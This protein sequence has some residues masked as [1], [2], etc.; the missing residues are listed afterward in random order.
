MFGRCLACFVLLVASIPA[1]A[2]PQRLELEWILSEEGKTATAVPQHAWLEDGRILLYDRRPPKSE[3]TL[4]I[5]DP[6][7][8]RTRKAIDANKVVA[9]MNRVLDPDEPLDEPGWPTDFSTDG[10]W[11]AYE[12]SGDIILL[13]LR[14][15]VVTAVAVSEAEE[16]SPK[17]SPDGQWLAFVR[18]NDLYARN[19]ET[20]SETRLTTGGTGTLMNGRL[21]WVYWEEF[22][23]RADR[24]FVW[25]PDS[26]SIA[27][28]QSDDS[29]VG[30]MHF[31]DFKP[32]LPRLVTQRHP[33]AGEPNP[34]VRAGV[35]NLQDAKTTWIDMG[36]YPY[37]YLPRLQWLPDSR[38]LA[39]Q[40]LNRSQSVLD[41]FLADAGTGQATHLMRET[42]DGWVNVHDDLYFLRDGKH[43]LWLSERSGYAHLYLYDLDGELV[44]Q[45]TSGDFA[46]HASGSKPGFEQ[47]V[48]FLDEDAG[49]VHF[50][51]LGSDST[52]RHLYRIGLD[53][54]AMVRSS[55]ADGSHAISFSP[56]GEHYLD[57]FSA[58]DRPPSLLL[59]RADGAEVAA[60]A[61]P[62]VDIADRFELQPWQMF[63]IAARDGYRLPAQMLKPR[64]FDEQ[65]T[66]PA[67]IYVYGG[68]SAPTVI[69]SWHGS[70]RGLYHQLLADSG[71]I[72]LYVDN[73]SAAGRSKRDANSIL[74]QLYGTVELED[75]LD[76]VAWLKAQPY[77]DPDR[78]GIWGWS[79]GGAMTL[80]AMT[81]S[82]EF[83]AGIAVAP[84]SDWRY[85]DTVYTERYM[86]RPEDNE[87]GYAKSSHVGRATDLHGRLLLVHGTYDDNVH[88]QNSWAFGDRLIEAGITF[89]MMIYPMRKH[90]ISD[91]AAQLHLYKTM[92][93]FWNR[94]LGLGD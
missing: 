4:A 77:V 59:R 73:R 60:V 48:S 10:R 37:E 31:V 49:T 87:D 9:A 44:R 68:P 90:G 93:E 26:R 79:G 8:G 42:N 36:A 91:D 54:S 56:R 46:L 2:Q 72:V 82:A 16:M 20:A 86:K 43:F 83:A 55:A 81:S 78:V 52:Q 7:N 34:R 76:G 1:S 28:L 35:V 71:V 65:Q 32:D 67:V 18:H 29:P 21:S 3:R 23:N 30:L 40:T 24:G 94:N 84:V 69:N 27:Y 80:Q 11:A 57:S 53:G 63:T 47:A 13:D 92:L 5:F 74:R 33:K 51:A 19:L 25:S 14:N 88:P 89:D 64:Y 6:G 50:T 75:L 17:F 70:A 62:R 12:K 22:M 38:R 58:I 39:L 85:Y 41:I 66:Y 61:A 45:V 15:S